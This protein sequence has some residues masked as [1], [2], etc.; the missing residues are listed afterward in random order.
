[1]ECTTGYGRLLGYDVAGWPYGCSGFRVF[2]VPLPFWLTPELHYRFLINPELA[3]NRYFIIAVILAIYW[4]AT[5]ANFYGTRLS[6]LISSICVI[7]GVFI[8]TITLIVLSVFYVRSGQ[9]IHMD[10]S[11]TLHDLLPSFGGSMPLF[12]SFIFGF[13]GIEVSA[14]HAREVHNPRRNY[15]IAVFSAAIV[16][17][18]LTLLGGM[19]IAF[20]LPAG[21]IDLVSGAMQTFAAIF[22][23]Y[24]LSWL[25][26]LAAFLISFGA[27]GQVS[28]WITGPVE[29]LFAA[30][31]A[32]NLP[33]IFQKQNAR[34]APRNLLIL[35][36]VLISFIAF[37]FLLVP[38]VSIGFLIL[39]SMAVLLYSMMYAI[40][41][42]AAIRLRYTHPDT[43][44]SYR[45]PCGN[46]GMWLVGVVGC[47]T[48][49]S[50][51]LIGFLPPEGVRISAKMYIYVMMLGV[52]F[53]LILPFI[54]RR[55]RKPDWS[56]Q[57]Q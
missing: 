56:A 31:R 5:F 17:F 53:L 16:G 10:F 12:L 21:N 50:C 46:A 15:P 36:A 29:G 40:M 52:G 51:F 35:Q 54:I 49:L 27:A 44:R 22:K 55:M 20:V 30:G 7:S 32:G 41:F 38:D 13:V 23:V 3:S 9:P 8:P 57:S 18:I 24:H 33:P 48:A 19:A 45:V 6:G 26:P 14:S 1:M 47:L 34:G 4:G 39:T 42:V 11:L 25:T 37:T 2:S 28:T 43:P